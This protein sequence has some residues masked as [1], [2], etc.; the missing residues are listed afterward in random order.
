ME[1]LLAIKL[2][3]TSLKDVIGQGGFSPNPD[4]SKIE[5][6][7]ADYFQISIEDLKSKKR[8]A[9]IAFPRQITMY[10]IRKLT[11]E[12]FPKIGLE[13]GGKDHSTVMHACEKISN[14]I[15]S[16]PSLKETITKLENDIRT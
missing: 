9:D 16:N 3:P 11:D 15:K 6:V 13:F 7:V 10:L 8:N 12:S 4:V 2:R 1:D 5:R 14:E